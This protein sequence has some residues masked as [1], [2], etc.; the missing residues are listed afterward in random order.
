MRVLVAGAAGQLGQAMVQRL[1]GE[2]DVIAWT[3]ADVDLTAHRDVRDRIVAA[4]PQA[5]AN[6]AGYN[7]VDR[8]EE[9]QITAMD[10]NAMAV[11]TM[12]RAAASCGAVFIH[13]STDFVFAG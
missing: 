5:I 13:Y 3:R 7:Q 6:C 9:D 10:V 2:H 4:A 11:G 12:A 8:A 1:G